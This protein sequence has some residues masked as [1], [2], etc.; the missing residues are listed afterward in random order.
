VKAGQ[1]LLLPWRLA[2]P[3]GLPESD[4]RWSRVLLALA[5]TVLMAAAIY[6]DFHLSLWLDEAYTLDTVRRP[7]ADTFHQSLRF[8][9]QPPVYFLLLNAWLR[10]SP[11]I[12]WARLFS[13]L[14]LALTLW[15][16]HRIAK[17]LG[18]ASSPFSLPLVAALCP[19]LVWAASEARCYAL[20]ALLTT[21]ATYFFVRVWVVGAARSQRDMA[22]YVACAYLALMTFYYAAFVL[23][24]QLLAG[25]LVS[26][27][28]R[29]LLLSFLALGLLLLP[30]VP[31]IL[32]QM[33]AH[34]DYNE[35]LVSPSAGA[36]LLWALSTLRHSVFQDVPVLDRQGVVPFL[37]ALLAVVVLLRVA[38]RSRH[39]TNAET[40]FGMLATVPFIVL[41]GFRLWH[42]FLVED[43][44]YIILAVNLPVF[45]ALLVAR[46]SVG[47]V[48]TIVA[49][50]F[51]AF[52][53]ASALSYQRNR[54]SKEDWRAAVSYLVRRAGP[55]EPILFAEA[56]AVLP[57][58]YYY[59]GPNPLHGLPRDHPLDSW[60]LGDVTIHDEGELRKRVAST[61]GPMRTFWLVDRKRPKA[62]GGAILDRLVQRDV[63][64]IETRDFPGVRVLHGRTSAAI[65]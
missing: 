37:T 65:R 45:V 40:V 22:L 54:V 2:R 11:T 7:L 51:I 25:L 41:T 26:E 1:G 50:L 48:R 5:I 62:F 34:P 61:V 32:T 60:A 13:T 38:P 56:D 59:R 39:W 36:F 63:E 9:L 49:L 12:E 43:R 44:Y 10:I 35:P 30:W 20:T 42:V 15:V 27:R 19:M 47:Y 28:R 58:R 24:A 31:T 46:I 55:A 53:A 23:A 8:E 17:L 52:F 4:E 64:V 3:S 21:G 14:A 18:M 6:N 57:F 33:A 29:A 16:L